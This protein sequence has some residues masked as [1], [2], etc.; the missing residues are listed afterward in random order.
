MLTP[1]SRVAAQ[2]STETAVHFAR[3]AVAQ[4]RVCAGYGYLKIAERIL[5]GAD[6]KLRHCNLRCYV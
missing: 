1:C 4:S 2:E 6:L 3:L 5:T